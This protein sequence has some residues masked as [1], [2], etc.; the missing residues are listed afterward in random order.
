MLQLTKDS[1]RQLLG[2]G[3]LQILDTEYFGLILGRRD[4]HWLTSH[5]SRARYRCKNRN[6]CYDTRSFWELLVIIEP[7]Y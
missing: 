4:W 2:S 1:R 6:W 7:K 5:N 3:G